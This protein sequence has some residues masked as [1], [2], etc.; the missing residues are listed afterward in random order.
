MHLRGALLWK[1]S[2][3]VVGRHRARKSAAHNLNDTIALEIPPQR[4]H[5]GRLWAFVG[6]AVALGVEI[7]ELDPIGIA[8][9]TVCSLAYAFGVFYFGDATRGADPMV[10]TLHAVA[11]AALIFVPLA[12]IE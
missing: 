11:T 7:R 5:T 3:R 6:L 9:A 1:R 4:R 2:C 12:A 10:V 8:S